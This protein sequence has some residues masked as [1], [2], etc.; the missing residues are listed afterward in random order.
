MASDSH[1]RCDT[2]TRH[3]S[4]Q[5]CMNNNI[6]IIRHAE[7]PIAGRTEG[8]RVR[9]DVDESSLTARGWQRAGALVAFFSN[10]TSP[11]LSR[12]DR[13]IAVRFDLG[14][15]SSSRRSRQTL[16]P[17]SEKLGLVCDQRF[18]EGQEELLVAAVQR[19]RGTTLIAWS[20]GHIPKIATMLAPG[21]SVPAEWP[22]DRFD[23]VW[24]IDRSGRKTTFTQV[25]Q[26]LLAGDEAETAPVLA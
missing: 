14:V 15:T 25:A 18:G 1:L 23:L 11:Q 24:V 7:K 3:T 8:V 6:M 17:L 5:E 2:A 26:Q 19:L 10:P 13:T 21:L 12:P 22:E 9:G 16:R 20:H 4:Q